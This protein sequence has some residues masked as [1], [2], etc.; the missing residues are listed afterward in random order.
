MALS[1]FLP[2]LGAPLPVPLNHA[3]SILPG[4]DLATSSQKPAWIPLGGN[5][6]PA[7]RLLE[8]SQL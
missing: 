7:L 6:I 4:P 2:R 1:P 3:L 5:Q 8:T